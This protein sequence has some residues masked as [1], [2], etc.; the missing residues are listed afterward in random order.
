M[1]TIIDNCRQAAEWSKCVSVDTWM[2]ML[3]HIKVTCIGPAILGLAL[4]Q[5]SA[6]GLLVYRTRCAKS[7]TGH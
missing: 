3:S 6:P 7:G 4:V 2:Q 1:Q 5:N